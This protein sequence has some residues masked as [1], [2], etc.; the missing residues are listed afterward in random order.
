MEQYIQSKSQ[1][2]NWLT[3]KFYYAL[4]I[5][6]LIDVDKCLPNDP[7]NNHYDIYFTIGTVI[8]NTSQEFHFVN[9]ATLE[10][11]QFI[12]DEGNVRGTLDVTIDEEQ[13]LVRITGNDLEFAFTGNELHEIVGELAVPGDYESYYLYFDVDA[14]KPLEAEFLEL[15]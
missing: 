6:K 15:D 10:N 12:I 13:E 5:S 3:E 7:G 4:G 14:T 9:T 1:W 2:E 11:D 8:N